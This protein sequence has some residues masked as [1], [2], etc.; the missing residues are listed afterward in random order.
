MRNVMTR[1]FPDPAPARIRSGPSVCRTASRCSGLSLSRKSIEGSVQYS[2][3]CV[4][5]AMGDV[6]RGSIAEHQC[7][8]ESRRQ[9]KKQNRDTGR[10]NPAQVLALHPVEHVLNPFEL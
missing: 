9:G 10:S 5:W 4:R 2:G 1:V 3:D 8:Y 7:D 6:S